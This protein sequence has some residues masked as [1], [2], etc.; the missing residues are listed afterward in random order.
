MQAT[1]EMLI[2]DNRKRDQSM[3]NAS[4][5]ID[6]VHNENLKLKS[7]IQKRSELIEE[8][9]RQI[10]ELEESKVALRNEARESKKL[11]TIETRLRSDISSLTG[12]KLN[13][14]K[15]LA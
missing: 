8:Q 9:K 12:E 3:D 5:I 15:E 4:S 13:L 11:K 6:S 1:I 2:S 14:Q 10:R 7:I